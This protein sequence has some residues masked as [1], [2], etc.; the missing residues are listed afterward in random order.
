MAEAGRPKEPCDLCDEQFIEIL[1]LYAQGASDVEIRAYIITKRPQR[2]FSYDLFDRWLDE[3]E[4]FS[5]TIKKGRM[6]SQCWWERNGRT[7]LHDKDFSATLWYMNMK[8][9]FGWKDKQETEHG[10]ADS[11]MQKLIDKL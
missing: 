3:E 4:I 1:D 10:A 11:L 9:R 2:T 7:N 5:E 6:L 8:N